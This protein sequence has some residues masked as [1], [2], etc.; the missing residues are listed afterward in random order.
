MKSQSISKYNKKSLNEAIKGLNVA[1]PNIIEN[2]DIAWESI[3]YMYLGKAYIDSH[4]P[5]K[6][7]PYLKKVDSIFNKP[8]L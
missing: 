3:S 1:L 5:E 2:Q 4:Q 7:I 8:I 6:G